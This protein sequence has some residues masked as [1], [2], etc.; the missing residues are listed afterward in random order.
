MKN[1]ECSRLFKE[2]HKL[3]VEYNNCNERIIKNKFEMYYL[4]KY[5]NDYP[6][7]WKR[8][9]EMLTED[10]NYMEQLKQNIIVLKDKIRKCN[11]EHPQS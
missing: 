1:Q 3:V 7:D 9:S 6:A 2:Y 4:W 11:I 5:K 8:K 10:R